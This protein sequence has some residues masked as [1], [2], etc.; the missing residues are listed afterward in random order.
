MWF[1]RRKNSSVVV[2]TLTDQG[3]GR[4]ALEG[5]LSFTS[6]PGL[7][8]QG[9]RLFAGAEQAIEVDLS[10]VRRCDSAGL[11]LM[12][13]WLSHARRLKRSLRF[14]HVPAQILRMAE[15]S[16]LENILPL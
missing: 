4:F 8:Q 7:L 5:K 6:V 12:V 9:A 1:L 14:Q 16:G 15:V 13:E 3:G 2:V 11:A 10:G